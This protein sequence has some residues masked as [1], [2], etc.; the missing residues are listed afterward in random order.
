MIL[1]Y[2]GMYQVGGRQLV[3]SIADFL[4]TSLIGVY[5]LKISDVMVKEVSTIICLNKNG[6]LIN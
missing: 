5:T 1:G 2:W 6:L 4:M 3:S